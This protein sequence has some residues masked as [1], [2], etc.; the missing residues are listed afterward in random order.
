LHNE[1]RNAVTIRPYPSRRKDYALKEGFS[2]GWSV[3]IILEK[4]ACAYAY[5]L[6]EFRQM[7]FLD[8]MIFDFDIN[9]ECESE[10]RMED[11]REKAGV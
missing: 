6:R 10:G 11:W 3:I 5:L 8:E 7:K 1:E 9:S 2:L 4:T